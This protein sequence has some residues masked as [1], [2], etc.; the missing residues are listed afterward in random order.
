MGRLRLF[1][2]LGALVAI[3]GCG[4]GGGGAGEPLVTGTLSGDYKGHAFTPAFG[5]ATIY[6][7]TNL[8]GVGDGPLNCDSPDSST[9]PRGTNAVF[10]L[11]TLAVGS[12]S[13]VFVQLYYN[14]SGFE[15]AGSN[16]GA[17]TITSVTG[18]SVAG[19]IDYSDTVDGQ[20]LSLSGSF[21]VTRCPG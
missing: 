1:V 20:P 4:G 7:G 10:S 5:F 3:T 17:V 2:G 18:G 15:G 16:T 21:E 8:I 6:S 14:V 9:P 19:S 12:Y 13:S 11:D